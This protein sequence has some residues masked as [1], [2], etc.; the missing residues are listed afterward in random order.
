MLTNWLCVYLLSSISRRMASSSAALTFRA[1]ASECENP[2]SSRTS[3][4][5]TCLGL[6]ATRFTFSLQYSLSNCFQ[7]LLCDVDVAPASFSAVLLEAVKDVDD[8][9]DL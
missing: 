9:V 7:S 8:I 2:K 4:L 3:P 5:V 6:L 1:E